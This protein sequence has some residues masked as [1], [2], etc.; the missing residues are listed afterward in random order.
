VT[1]EEAR[2]NKLLRRAFLCFRKAHEEEDR[3]LREMGKLTARRIGVVV[4]PQAIVYDN[5]NRK[6]VEVSQERAEQL[7]ESYAKYT[8]FL[9]CMGNRCYSRFRGARVTLKPW[10]TKVARCLIANAGQVVSGTELAG[11]IGADSPHPLALVR[12]KVHS[13]RNILR[14][15]GRRQNHRIITTVSGSG[16]MFSMGESYC[17]IDRP[18][19]QSGTMGNLGEHSDSNRGRQ[20]Q[21]RL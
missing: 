16:Y 19:A 4:V 5:C 17:L 18:V 10:Q 13:L 7:L 11:E 12:K 9:D 3:W 14:L 15:P 1:A 2:L 20:E 8:I 21:G 6:G